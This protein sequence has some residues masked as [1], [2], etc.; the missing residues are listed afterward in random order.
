MIH[1]IYIQRRPR[2][3]NFIYTDSQTFYIDTLCVEHRVIGNER[4]EDVTVI[5]TANC[6]P[7]YHFKKDL[8]SYKHLPTKKHGAEVKLGPMHY[9]HRLCR[10][11]TIRID[12]RVCLSGM[13]S[14]VSP[15]QSTWPI[16]STIS[17]QGAS[18]RGKQKNF[19][20]VSRRSSKKHQ[21][22]FNRRLCDFH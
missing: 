21:R 22:L 14:A 5:T 7:L 15:S 13:T 3:H 8:F 19:S 6:G 11:L 16:C 4:P 10:L 18:C 9:R 1:C 2:S 17:R 20:I 12:R